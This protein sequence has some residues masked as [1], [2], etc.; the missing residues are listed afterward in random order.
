MDPL[1]LAKGLRAQQ[2]AN[3]GGA[4]NRSA[5]TTALTVQAYTG[6]FGPSAPVARPFNQQYIDELANTQR[7]E[8]MKTANEKFKGWLEDDTKTFADLPAALVVDNLPHW[9]D[10]S[11]ALEDALQSSA[12]NL[13]TV[14]GKNILQ[15]GQSVVSA[16][17]A[18]G[19]VAYNDPT[20]LAYKLDV[21]TQIARGEQIDPAT[22]SRNH[23]GQSIADDVRAFM[24]MTPDEQQAHMNAVT[25]EV[26]RR[27]DVKG[28]AREPMVRTDV[29]EILQVPVR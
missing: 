7:F 28:R 22:L 27:Q 11:N 18:V 24:T 6:S 20:G 12:G 3:I 4:L 23:I 1:D 15:M 10:Y 8:V 9:V 17:G 26:L 13:M 5:G 29:P 19:K 25:S 16:V 2:D 14:Q 21:Y